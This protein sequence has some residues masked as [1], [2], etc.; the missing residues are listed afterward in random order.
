MFILILPIIVFACASVVAP[1]QPT[2]E[3][4]LADAI[5][6]IAYNAGI[7]TII[8]RALGVPFGLLLSETC[9]ALTKIPPSLSVQATVNNLKQLKSDIKQVSYNCLFG[10]SDQSSCCTGK[11][12]AA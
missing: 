7:D 9:Q 10:S 6:C 3:Q 2:L 11:G 4:E 12:V 1:S 8:H 5:S